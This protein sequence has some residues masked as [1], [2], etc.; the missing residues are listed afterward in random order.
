MRGMLPGVG[1]SE[2]LEDR[3]MLS[4]LGPELSSNVLPTVFSTVNGR[5]GESKV[6][7]GEVYTPGKSNGSPV[8]SILN[9]KPSESSPK[10]R[11][12]EMG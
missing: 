3:Q 2:R 8:V 11:V 7:D 1:A 4:A 12:P 10:P 5:L 9:S 6:I